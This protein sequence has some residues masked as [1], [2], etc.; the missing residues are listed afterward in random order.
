MY[1][2]LYCISKTLCECGQRGIPQWTH[3]DPHTED[4]AHSPDTHTHKR[5]VRVNMSSCWR[6]FDLLY[7][8]FDHIICTYIFCLLL[9]FSCSLSV[10]PSLKLTHTH[11][12]IIVFAT[13]LLLPWIHMIYIH[14]YIYI[15]TNHKIQLDLN[16]RRSRRDM[17]PQGRKRVAGMV[18]RDYRTVSGIGQSYHNQVCTLAK[19]THHSKICT[20]TFSTDSTT[21][22]QTQSVLFE[23]NDQ[24]TNWKQIEKKTRN[25]ESSHIHI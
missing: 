24:F 19:L 11:N 7:I 21:S 14:I 5:N 18:A 20:R 2:D 17:S 15:F 1:F 16:E 6:Q 10:F 25:F 23:Y 13:T 8:Y 4:S 3:R 9:S 12:T 22:R